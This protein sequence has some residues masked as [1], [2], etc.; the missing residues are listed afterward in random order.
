VKPTSSGKE[1]EIIHEVQALKFEEGSGEKRTYQKAFI[2][3]MTMHLF[4]SVVAQLNEA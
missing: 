2:M 3:R 4:S 1:L